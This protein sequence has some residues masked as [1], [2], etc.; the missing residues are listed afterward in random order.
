MNQYLYSLV[1]VG[2][3]AMVL[4][5]GGRLR[6]LGAAVG[7]LL[8]VVLAR[9][10]P[11]ASFSVQ[12]AIVLGLALMGWLFVVFIRGFLEVVI[13]VIGA[14][15]GAAITLGL[16]QLFNVD[17]ILVTWVLAVIGGVIGLILIRRSRRG[18]RDWGMIILADLVGALLIVRGL[19]LL[20]PSLRATTWGSLLTLLGLLV[21][22]FIYQGGYLRRGKSTPP[23]SNPARPKQSPP[24]QK[25]R[26]PNQLSRKPRR[27]PNRS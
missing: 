12:L 14:L 23:L 13:L 11:D 17:E 8:G 26:N 18:S 27:P 4:L 7:G 19:G 3:G 6:V 22:G 25:P 2:L 10:I 21:F 1:V 20:F 5:F 9:L 24:R 15:A 16:L